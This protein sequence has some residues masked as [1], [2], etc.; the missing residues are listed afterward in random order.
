MST[1]SG[2]QPL[3]WKP[4]NFAAS[5]DIEVYKNG[6][7]NASA[8]NRVLS[9]NSKQ[10][11]YSFTRALPVSGKSYVWRVRRRTPTGGEAPGAPGGRSR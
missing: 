3:R 11:A 10:T 1:V 8:A 5:Y 4:L 9:A 6:D 7:T 2:T